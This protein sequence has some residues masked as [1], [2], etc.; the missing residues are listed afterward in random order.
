MIVLLVRVKM[1]KLLIAL[2]FISSSVSAELYEW[3]V[4]KVLDGDTIK[5]KVDFLPTPLP[6][7]LSVRVLGVDTPEKKPRNKCEQEDVLA[8]KASAFTKERV[9]HAQ[10]IQVNL[11]G[12]D[13]YGGRVLGDVFIDD[14]NLA[15]ELIEKGLAREYHGEAKSSW[16]D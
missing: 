14:A 1:K 3:K 16:C 9:A 2:M 13:K 12:W 10:K 8:Q 5:F 4:D 15:H 7:T 11:K 6:S